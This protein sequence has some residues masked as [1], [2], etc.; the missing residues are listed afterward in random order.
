MP[1][2]T[3]KPPQNVIDE[4]KKLRN[5]LDTDNDA[6]IPKK[7][8]DNILIAT[9]NIRAFGNLTKKWEA[10]SNDSPKRDLHS[11]LCI[12][13]I[14]K[15]FDVIAVQE[16]KNNIKCLRD[17]LRILGEEWSFIMTDVTKG[18]A[19]N[20][21]RLA[22]IFNTKRVKLSGLACEIVIPREQLLKIAP[23]ALD[24]QFARTP[25]AVGF[26]RKD[27]TFVLLTLHVLYGDDTAD[28]VPELKAIADW[29]YDWAKQLKRWKQSLIILGDFNIER[30]NDEA[31]KAFVSNGLH[32]PEE[33]RDLPSTIFK[34][35]KLYDQIAWYK[36]KSGKSQINLDFQ[37]GGIIDFRGHV[38]AERDYSLSK[39][40]FRISDHFPLW[41]EFKV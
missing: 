1:L 36:N 27:K 41:C 23:D 12:I 18:D 32:I 25:Y 37:T 13:E 20:G 2:I 26:K 15:S 6:K 9:W 3:D 22:F 8:D 4:I 17:T 30:K 14:I 40:S 7:Q 5:Y 34:E 31:Y 19:G 29:M 38:L 39:L 28:R 33:I 10:T 21:E 16:V 24:R 11:L 35:L